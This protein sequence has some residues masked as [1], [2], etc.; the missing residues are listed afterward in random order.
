MKDQKSMHQLNETSFLSGGNDYYLENLYETY[1][2]TPDNVE[3]EWRD[4][5]NQLAL[6][7]KS[8]DVS[9]SSCFHHFFD[10]RLQDKSSREFFKHLT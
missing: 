9:H 3:P 6:A 5:F 10:L 4:Y 8:V 1:L 2:K 7:D